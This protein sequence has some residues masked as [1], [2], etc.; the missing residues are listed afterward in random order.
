MHQRQTSLIHAERE[1]IWLPKQCRMGYR[2]TVTWLANCHEWDRKWPPSV[3]NSLPNG[4]TRD[5]RD[6]CHETMTEISQRQIPLPKDLTW[7][8]NERITGSATVPSHWPRCLPN[9]IPK[10][11][12]LSPNGIPDWMPNHLTRG[13]PNDYRETN[14]YSTET[15][16][17][18]G[19]REVDQER[20][21]AIIQMTFTE[22]QSTETLPDA[23]LTDAESAYAKRL[24]E[25][26]CA[27]LS[28]WVWPPSLKLTLYM[29]QWHTAHALCN[30]RI[31]PPSNC[32]QR[33]TW[34]PTAMTMPRAKAHIIAQSQDKV[35]LQLTSRLR[36][37]GRLIRQ[38][39][40]SW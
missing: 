9:G 35:P 38:Q 18:D 21:E 5:C 12:K 29:D 34:E 10:D 4:T 40:K 30:W 39:S 25:S 7:R 3:P 11:Q 17:Q 19:Q 23:E 15:A 14:G 37:L 22:K 2:T 28:R 8:S 33:V 20:T 1:Q 16:Y 36:A 6:N 13:L 24:S 32:H 31:L 26:R 27:L